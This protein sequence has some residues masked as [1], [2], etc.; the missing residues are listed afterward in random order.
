MNRQR[1]NSETIIEDSDTF[2]VVTS[3]KSSAVV[4]VTRR[5]ESHAFIDGQ[6]ICKSPSNA[7]MVAK[8]P[9]AA[10]RYNAQ[11]TSADCMELRAHKRL[12]KVSLLRQLSCGYEPFIRVYT[13]NSEYEVTGEAEAFISTHDS[14]VVRCHAGCDPSSKEGKSH[15]SKHNDDF[16]VPHDVAT[17]LHLS[18]PP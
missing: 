14:A 7:L 6:S 2:L 1:A 11:S 18:P 13:T 5:R 15:K 10:T 16:V 9:D 3:Q 17:L 12:N 8:S 4:P